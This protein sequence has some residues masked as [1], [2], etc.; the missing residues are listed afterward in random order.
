[1]PYK[2]PAVARE[3]AKLRARTY[4]ARHPERWGEI[5]RKNAK[6]Q[7]EVHSDEVSARKFIWNLLDKGRLTPKGCEWCGANKTNAHHHKGYRGYYKAVIIWLC[8]SCHGE[9]HRK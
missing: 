8:D 4:R 7:R 6:R 3:H 2:D 1:M 9:A 5:N